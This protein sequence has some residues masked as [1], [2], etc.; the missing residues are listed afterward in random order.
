[1]IYPYSPHTLRWLPWPTWPRGNWIA[2]IAKIGTVGLVDTYRVLYTN[3]TYFDFTIGNWLWDVIWPSSATDNAVVRFDTTTW[4]LIQNSWI[5]IDDNG[6]LKLNG[7]N[8]TIPWLQIRATVAWDNQFFE[9]QNDSSVKR[10]SIVYD[11][12]TPWIRI[13]DRSGGNIFSIWEATKNIGINTTAHATHKVNLLAD[14][15]TYGIYI[16]KSND[17][18]AL[19]IDSTVVWG[20]DYGAFVRKTWVLTS[21]FDWAI[22]ATID[23]ASTTNARTIQSTHLWASGSAL[24]AETTVGATPLTLVNS[25]TSVPIKITPWTNW[26]AIAATAWVNGA[27]PAQVVWYLVIEIGW[28]NRK[29]PYYAL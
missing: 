7:S 29:I 17:W 14:T 15:T 16:A 5:T 11:N 25:W 12:T 9:F 19:F 20:N 1:M 28:T 6:T 24:Y 3:G 27:T 8:A 26:T 13:Q 18:A 2:S 22:Y 4:K 21:A 23:N 10:M